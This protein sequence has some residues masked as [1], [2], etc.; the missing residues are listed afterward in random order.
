MSMD[1][2]IGTK[3]IIYIVNVDWFFISHRLPIAL[4]AK[5][6]GYTV[7]IACNFT[8]HKEELFDMGFN[9][10]NIPFTR[11]GGGLLNE[12]KTII[13]IRRVIKE[14]KPSLVHAVTIKPV[15]YTGLAL[16]TITK[17][18]PMVAAISG[19]GYVFTASNLRAK[20]TRFVASIC[21]KVALTQKYKIVIFQ[22]S[23]DDAILTK[24][25]DLK[26]GDKALIKGSGADLSIYNALA[27]S[28]SDVIKVVMACRLLKEKGVYEYI[29]AAKQV[30][31]QCPETEFLLVGTPDLENPNTVEQ[32][33]IDQWVSGGVINY[34]GHRNDIPNVFAE[35]NIVCLPSFYGE[36]VPKVL[37][38]AAACGRA[39]I[40]TNNPGCKDAI[41][42]GVTGIAVPVRDST[43]LAVAIIKLIEDSDLRNVMGHKGRLFA[44]QEFD[45]NSVV[46]K[47]LKIYNNLISKVL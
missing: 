15:L 5:K 13:Y 32:T 6:R 45:V 34:L 27:E 1:E 18:I 29:E 36:G 30:K 47:H 37:I 44:E 12:L 46:H 21:Y 17:N 38:E 26:C 28:N 23:S 25:A 9:V 8:K 42:D 7:T 3:S 4:E 14:I 33:E 2:F 16:K 41:I 22:N 39:I 35:S 43:A 24:V 10:I 20:L 31:E 19:L 11:S 40:T